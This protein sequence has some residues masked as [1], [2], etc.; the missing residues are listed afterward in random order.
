MGQVKTHS[1]LDVDQ[2]DQPL[3]HRTSHDIF[4]CFIAFLFEI[5]L[6]LIL[7]K[8]KAE[9]SPVIKLT[10]ELSQQLSGGSP[11]VTMETLKL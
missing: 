4:I 5:I 11:H 2:M 3:L 10:V 1:D 7:M 9:S 8:A 6:S